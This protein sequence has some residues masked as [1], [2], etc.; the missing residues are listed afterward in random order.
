MTFSDAKTLYREV[1]GDHYRT[2]NDARS[3]RRNSAWHLLNREG[4][5]LA[6]VQ[7]DGSVAH[8]SMLLRVILA[9]ATC[10]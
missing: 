1:A 5:L 4:A 10:A 8:G 6:V 7:A 2:P 3:Y 9:D